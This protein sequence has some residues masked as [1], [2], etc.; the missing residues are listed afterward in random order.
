MDFPNEH[1]LKKVDFL[2]NAD[3]VY[4]TPEF[5]VKQSISTCLDD[6]CCGV[7][8][9]D[10]TYYR[11]TPKRD[12]IYDDVFEFRGDDINGRRMKAG[13]YRRRYVE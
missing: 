3:I 10:D 4:R 9:S 2:A 7:I 11:R 12:N 6:N 8:I 1:C 13:M 5:I